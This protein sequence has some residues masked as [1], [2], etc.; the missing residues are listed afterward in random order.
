MND[1]KL[2]FV[3]LDVLSNALQTFVVKHRAVLVAQH[4]LILVPF[5]GDASV[6]QASRTQMNQ[7]GTTKVVDIVLLMDVGFDLFGLVHFSHDVAFQVVHE[8]AVRIRSQVFGLG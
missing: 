5:F 1:F 2:D 8:V 3:Q 7:L 4:L 6:Q